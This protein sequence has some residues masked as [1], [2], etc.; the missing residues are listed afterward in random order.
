ML[1]GLSAKV[2]KCAQ[3]IKKSSR[4]NREPVEY[5]CCAPPAR[6]WERPC[7]KAYFEVLF[8]PDELVVFFDDVFDDE[9]F[10][11][12]VFF[13][14]AVFFTA[15]FL[16]DVFFFDDATDFLDELFLVEVTFLELL[17]ELFVTLLLE[18]PDLESA[19]RAAAASASVPLVTTCL[20]VGR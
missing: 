13:A 6:I 2:P 18:R 10:L 5:M 15:V 8:L 7:R 9:V 20:G 11:T 19:L 17:E 1:N 14:E 4:M 16:P 12:E 3:R